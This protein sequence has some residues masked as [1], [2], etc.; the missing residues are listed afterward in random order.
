MNVGIFAVITVAGGYDD[1]RSLIEDYRGLIYRA[2]LVGSL[3]LFF[4]V[5]LVGIPFT[6]GFFGKFYSFS[7]A[8]DNG[9]IALAMIGLL[10]SGVAAA[11]YLR[12]ALV[13]VQRPLEDSRRT[14]SAPRLGVA[15]GAALLLAAAATLALGI[16]PSETLRAAES[17]AH[18]LQ[19]PPESAPQADAPPT[20]TQP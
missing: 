11:Y 15:V 5:S 17:A 4:L 10:N 16:V 7:A 18:T 14:V 8:V 6:G 13:S 12:F 19:A 20:Q 2:P 9:A 1:K 3:L